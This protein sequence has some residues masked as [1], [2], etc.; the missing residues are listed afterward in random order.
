MNPGPDIMTL[1]PAYVLS[2]SPKIVKTEKVSDAFQKNIFQIEE[3][4]CQKK[5]D[6][7]VKS[8]KI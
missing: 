2:M 3:K 6:I 5:W 7:F 1:E 8:S 4:F